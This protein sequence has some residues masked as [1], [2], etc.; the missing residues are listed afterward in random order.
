M[1]SLNN[2]LIVHRNEAFTIDKTI[3]NKDGSPYIISSELN[4]PYFLITVSNTRYVVENRYI[5][6]KWLNLENFPRF[7]NTNAVNLKIFKNGSSSKYNSFD[8]ITSLTNN[9]LI[10]PESIILAGSVIKKGT[11]LNGL[12]YDDGQLAV[13]ISINSNSYIADGSSIISGSTLKQGSVINF[14][15]IDTDT[16]LADDLEITTQLLKDI[17]AFGEVN[18]KFYISE[19]G[20]DVFYA[21]EN[22]VI[23]YKYWKENVGWTEY[24][25]RIITSY[26]QEITK[27]WI[28][29]N[30]VYSITLVSASTTMRQYLEN[31]CTL[32]NIDF[33]ETTTNKQMYD[34]LEEAGYA[35]DEYFD[36]NRPIGG[37]YTTFTPILVPTKMTVSSNTEGKL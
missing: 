10:L 9:N 22:G 20:D 7:R 16:I 5:Y 14:I 12:E 28:D 21:E 8:D 6:S 29:Q 13:D 30:Y 24:I 15:D 37:P 18:G 27:Q 1:K 2:E 19:I 17:V 34:E 32:Y 33:N 4:N 11:I 25:C 31:L 23:K 36:Y 26:T 35:F 3:Q